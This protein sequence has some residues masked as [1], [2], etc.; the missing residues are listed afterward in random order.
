MVT[1][2]GGLV[3]LREILDFSEVNANEIYKVISENCKE[4]KLTRKEIEKLKAKEF[5]VDYDDNTME[6]VSLEYEEEQED[7]QNEE[8]MNFYIERYKSLGYDFTEEEL[9]RLLPPREYY[10]YESILHRLMAESLHEIHDIIIMKSEESLSEE[11]K[12]D[13][14]EMIDFERK[15]MTSVHG[16]LEKEEDFF[17]ESKKNH[18]ILLPTTYGNIRIIEELEHIPFE[19]YPAFLDLI[20]SIENNC[21]KDPNVFSGN[22]IVRGLTE[23]RSFKVRVLFMRLTE[24]YYVLISAFVKKVDTDKH[25]NNSVENKFKDYMRK[26]S[27]LKKLIH[28]EEFMKQNDQNLKIL[29]DLLSPKDKEKEFCKGEK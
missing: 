17:V 9:Q 1:I 18:L 13:C 28:D 6:E 11:E 15:K 8:E 29:Y 22:S 14:E 12:K 27:M 5:E 10:N 7:N 25:Y 19:Y 24:D 16:M 2:E 21:F 3:M 20:K 23:V 26:E 4:S